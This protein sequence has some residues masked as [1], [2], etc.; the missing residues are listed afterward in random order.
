MTQPAFELPPPPALVPMCQVRCEVGA[1][2][3]LGPGPLGERRFVPLGGGTV[4]GPELN[5][6]LVAGGVDWQINRSDGAL[7]IA[8]HYVMRLADGALV[9]VQSN[10]LRHGPPQVMASLARGETVERG[11]YYFRTAVR[12]TT[13]AAAWL[14]LN[15][16][17]ALA[18]G[19]REA[20]LVVLDFY[21]LT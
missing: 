3:T 8:A 17:L 1:L 13:A 14:H 9:E 21:R 18:V 6:S 12:F 4:R 16:T 5:G 15:K 10:G 7:E 20:R 2:V 19:Q 11:A